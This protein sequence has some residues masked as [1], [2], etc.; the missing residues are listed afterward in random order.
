[1]DRA[2]A[3][4][5]VCAGSIPVRRIPQM[6]VY[7]HKNKEQISVVNCFA[8]DFCSFFIVYVTNIYYYHDIKFI[9]PKEGST[10]QYITQ[11]RKRDIVA[12][13][14]YERPGIE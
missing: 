1:M 5:A 4:D 6:A 3:S 11:P 8:T 12:L 9:A 13:L 7:S 10:G 2:S 14:H